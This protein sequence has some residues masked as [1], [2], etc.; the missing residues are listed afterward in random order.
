MNYLL[1]SIS[2]SNGIG[3]HIYS[4]SSTNHFCFT[5][6]VYLYFNRNFTCTKYAVGSKCAIFSQGLLVDFK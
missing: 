6:T 1:H 5:P 2:S 4:Q 3:L